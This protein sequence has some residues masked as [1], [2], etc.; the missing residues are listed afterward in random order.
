VRNALCERYLLLLMVAH[1]C[2][3]IAGSSEVAPITKGE[4]APLKIATTHFEVE[5]SVAPDLGRGYGGLCEK[6]YGKFCKIF[7][8]KPDEK[9]W[10]DKCKVYLFAKREQFVKFAEEVDKTPIGAMSGGY[11]RPTKENPHIVLFIKGR[12]HV[13]LQQ[14]LIHEMTHVFLQLFRK[15][16]FVPTWLHEGFAQYFEFCH[17]PGESREKLSRRVVKSMV[18]QNR[19]IP[20]NVFFVSSFPPTDLE[21]YAQ[22]WSLI[23]FITGNKELCRKTG[24]LVLKLKES[25]P[26]QRAEV[27][28]DG[29]GFKVTITNGDTL[30]VQEEALKEIFGVSVSQFEAMWKRYVMAAY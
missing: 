18:K 20:L 5:F 30:K 11:T 26:E 12:E 17:V 19:A 23:D 28:A 13:K 2:G 9:V 27:S 3:V 14:T 25:S 15:E 24:R 29:E 4:H 22:A 8:V 16:T 1:G 21:S 7:D 10:D 6:A